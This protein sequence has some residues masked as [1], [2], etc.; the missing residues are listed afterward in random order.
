MA[1]GV[2]VQPAAA[3]SR[4][5]TVA[6]AFTCLFVAA[7]PSSSLA[8]AETPRAER[9]RKEALGELRGFRAGID[10][11]VGDAALSRQQVRSLEQSFDAMRDA[12][13]ADRA[14]LFARALLGLLA[15]IG[16]FEDEGALPPGTSISAL[17]LAVDVTANLIDIG[18]LPPDPGGGVDAIIRGG[19]AAASNA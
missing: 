6:G 5:L 16:G 18:F 12:I 19:L 15:T 9:V 7:I 1:E 17:D 10:D 11:L 8:A 13:N 4:I 3:M 14:N 2:P